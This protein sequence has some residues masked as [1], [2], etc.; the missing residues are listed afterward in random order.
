MKTKLFLVAATLFAS[1]TLA[2]QTPEFDNV[3]Y[4]GVDFSH[5]KAYGANETGEK[6]KEAFAHINELTITEWSKYDPGKFLDTPIMQQDITATQQANNGIDPSKINTNASA[7]RKETL[8]PDQ[9]AATVRGYELAEK[10]GTGLVIVARLLDKSAGKGYFSAVY[11]D[12]AT[13][14]VLSVR[15]MRGKVGGFGLRNFWAG[16]LYDAMKRAK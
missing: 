12:I 11:F 6:F 14:E 13:R 15:E 9:L 7:V 5:A 2:A 16:S 8:T 4:Y 1:M 10:E 3:T